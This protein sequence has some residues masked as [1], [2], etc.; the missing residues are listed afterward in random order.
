MK[1]MSSLFL[2]SGTGA[3]LYLDDSLFWLFMVPTMILAII[4]LIYE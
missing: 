1:L 3:G 4:G 2:F